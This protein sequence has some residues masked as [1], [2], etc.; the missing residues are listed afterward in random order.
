MTGSP[1]SLRHGAALLATLLAA[2]VLAVS[3]GAVPGRSASR[4]VVNWV[5][6]ITLGANGT[7]I[8]GN[9][10]ARVKLTEFVSYTCPHCAHLSA[11]S[12]TPL[13]TRY[14]AS[15]NVSVEVRSIVR[16]PVDMTAA[17]LA[18]CGGDARFFSRHEALMAQHESMMTRVRA[19]PQT[20]YD[21]WA[22]GTPAQRLR[23][24]ATDSGLLAWAQQR[25]MTQAQISTCFADTAL[26]Q[27]LV[28]Q[29]TH[30]IAASVTG[31][32][33]FAINGELLTE[34]H[35][36]EQLQPALDSALHPAAAQ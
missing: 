26:Q 15:G 27:R 29:T 10:A 32:P 22:V 7:H 3:A 1:R 31:T 24:I 6:R 9:P 2:A 35:S 36:W 14:V 17:V 19:L 28:A 5:S 25:G 18:N 33:S 8:M 21:Q 13:R 4:A 23:R 11:V 20:T 12:S 30:D 16:D 34:P